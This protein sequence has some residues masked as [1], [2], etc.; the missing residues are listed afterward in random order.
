MGLKMGQYDY[1]AVTAMQEAQQPRGVYA[2]IDELLGNG[3]L[4]IQIPPPYIRRS[5]D[6]VK[7]CGQ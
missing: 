1:K 2:R 6:L 3:L 4:K 5:S 7:G